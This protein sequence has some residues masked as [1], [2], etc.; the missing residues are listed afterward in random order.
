VSN[1]RRRS[2]RR[3]LIVLGFDSS[4]LE[5]K[6]AEKVR[7]S[8]GAIRQQVRNTLESAIKVGQELLAVKEALPHGQFLPWQRAEFQWAGRTAYNFTSVATRFKVGTI[9]NL[10][11]DPT[12]AYLLAAPFTSDE[13]R[14][15]VVELAEAGEKITTAVSK[16]IVAEAKKIGKK[17]AKPIP[18][19]MLG[20]AHKLREFADA[21]E[22]PGRRTKK[23][24]KD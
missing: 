9:A 8:A 15:I 14:Q 22:K 2:S 10:P 20:L 3:E 5:A 19:E 6:V 12:T 16:E 17:K 4:P 11:K 1:D 21:L 24:A 18:A 7:S 13:A 23:K